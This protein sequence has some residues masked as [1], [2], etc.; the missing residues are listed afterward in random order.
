MVRPLLPAALAR[1][2]RPGPVDAE[3]WSLLAANA[4]V[5]AKLRHH[6]GRRRRRK[7]LKAIGAGRRDRLAE[8]LKQGERHGVSTGPVGQ[9]TYA[10]RHGLRIGAVA[11]AAVIFVFQ[12]RPTA[13][14]I[15][16]LVI[17]LLLVLGLI[18][19]IGRPPSQAEPAGQSG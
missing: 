1:H 10:H 11:L 7:L 18:E 13:A 17:I 19:L 3:G 5:A 14:S 15:I 6:V 8:H 9:W 16:V 4:G 2:V 12:G